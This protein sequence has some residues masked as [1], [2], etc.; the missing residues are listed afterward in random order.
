MRRE[1]SAS[2]Q[3]SLCVRI[4]KKRMRPPRAVTSTLRSLVEK[5]FGHDVGE[6]FENFLGKRLTH[7]RVDEH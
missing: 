5:F 6:S 2:C 7:R 1:N 3:K 4:Q